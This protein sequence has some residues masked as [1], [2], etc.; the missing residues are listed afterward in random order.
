MKRTKK[1][2]SVFI[3]LI[4]T[5]SFVACGSENDEGS[6]KHAN[7]GLFWIDTTIDNVEGYNGWVLCRAGI[8]ESLIKINDDMSYEGLIAESWENDN[9]LTWTFKIRDNIT[10][11]N[12]KK[13]DGEAVKKSLERS[14]T[15][16]ERAASI[17]NID[18]IEADGQIVIIKTKEPYASLIGNLAEPLFSIVD[19]ESGEF[20]SNPICTGPYVVTSF[21]AEKTIKVVKNENYWNGEVGLDS[22]TFKHIPDS[23]TRTMALQSGEVDITVT[24]DQSQVGVFKN[25]SDYIVDEISSLRTLFGYINHESK[26]L[27]DKNIRKAIAHS[28]DRESYAKLIGGTPATGLFSDSLSFGN[29]KLQCDEFSL[30]EANKILDN[31]GY[32]DSNNDGIR[33]KDGENIIINIYQTS[34]HGSDDPGTIAV[35]M[36]S[37]LKDIGINAEIKTIE[38]LNA[39]YESGEFDI[40]FSNDNTGITGDPQSFLE[41][42]YKTNALRNYG[43]YSSEEMDKLIEEL[44][45]EFD[46][47]K[48]K[49]IAIKASQLAIDDVVNLYFTYIPLNI[50]GKSNVKNLKQ[51]PIDY[52]MITKDVTIE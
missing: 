26:T 52:Y 51:H 27:S 46:S 19:V 49:N 28:I 14:I 32:V 30:H 13:V 38:N 10:F 34:A 45:G 37:Q 47:E 50:V 7:V 23:N 20:D 39:I 24:I 17:S 5:F 48:R 15:E 16:S 22:I 1:L 3:T 42:I 40:T 8:S 18:T 6:S 43:K 36:Q 33:E 4:L 44:N 12:G 35:A 11:S 41:G 31:A 9:N 25:N 21:T 29:E 2:I